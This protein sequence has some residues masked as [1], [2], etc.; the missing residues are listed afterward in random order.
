VKDCCSSSIKDK[1]WWRN[2]LGVRRRTVQH[3]LTLGGS[4]SDE[5]SNRSATRGLN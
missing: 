1:Q 3:G 4:R 5:T 2:G